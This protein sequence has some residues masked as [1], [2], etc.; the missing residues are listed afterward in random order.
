MFIRQIQ[1]HRIDALR[2]IQIARQRDLRVRRAE[3]HD[4]RRFIN[5]IGHQILDRDVFV[6][7]A[8]HERGIRAVFQQASHQI[9]E[10]R[11][12]RAD[13]CIHAARTVQLVA[14]RDFFVERLAHAVQ[15]LEL[16]LAGIVVLAREVIDGRECMC[17][18]RG[19]L[20]IHRVRRTE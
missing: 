10:Q 16:V 8:V 11:F 5:R 1:P 18:V 9:R 17:V 15:A 19:E 3:R 12:M 20:R 2:T 14:A 6:S 7:D 4:L 13:R